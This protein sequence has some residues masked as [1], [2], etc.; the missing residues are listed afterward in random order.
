MPPEG[1]LAP[2]GGEAQPQ[3]WFL[4]YEV[5]REG[6][7]VVVHLWAHVDLLSCSLGRCESGKSPRRWVELRAPGTGVKGTD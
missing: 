4:K 5:P 7:V 6:M 3:S 2:D 1:S